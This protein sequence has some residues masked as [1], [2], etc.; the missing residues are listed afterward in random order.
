MGQM[1]DGLKIGELAGRCGVTRD[2]IRFY[3]RQGL[4]PPP[5]RTASRYRIYSGDDVSRVSFIRQAQGIGLS[6]DDIRELLR[7][8]RLNTPEQCRRVAARLR[9][10]L[11][12]LE[13]K[14]ARLQAFR[15]S[16]SEA[17]SRCEEADAEC[18]PVVLDLTDTRREGSSGR[19]FNG[20]WCHE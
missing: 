11:K 16:L 5:E 7:I 19:T 13:E 12:A 10:R 8:R 17:L 2:T 15:D 14:L 1:I 9:I 18:C 6:L 3:E 4:L 20:S